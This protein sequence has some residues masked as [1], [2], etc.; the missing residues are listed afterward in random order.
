MVAS[1]TTLSSL[2][3]TEST[4]EQGQGQAYPSSGF[5]NLHTLHLYGIHTTDLAFS[6]LQSLRRLSLRVS[7]VDTYDFTS[8][9]QLT[10][11]TITIAAVKSLPFRRETARVL[12]PTGNNVQL[13][14]LSISA[15]LSGRS[16]HQLH[17][18][19]HVTHITSIELYNTYTMNFLTS[20]WPLSMPCLETIK[21]EVLPVGHPS[22]CWNTHSCAISV[23]ITTWAP[24]CPPGSR[25]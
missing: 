2:T 18:L 3:L 12:V 6:R 19:Q 21:C 23:Y 5:A 22:S 14:N 1:M 7:L 24:S 10:S 4:H 9:T 16:F 17:N 15:V 25:S 8:C 13:Q 20:G 11:L